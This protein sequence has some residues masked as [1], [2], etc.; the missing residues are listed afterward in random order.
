MKHI[1]FVIAI[2]L[3]FITG[4]LSG[5]QYHINVNSINAPGATSKLKY[6]LFPGLKN[7]SDTDL[8]YREYAKYV[9][10][11]MIIKGYQK[12]QSLSEADIA[13]Y[14]SYGIGEPETKQSTVSIPIVGQTGIS[15]VKTTGSLSTFGNTATYSEN[16]TYTPTY[17][18]T[19]V[20]TRTKSYTTY[21]RYIR[22]I[23]I[24]LNEYRKTNKEVQVWNTTVTSTGTSG[25]LRRVFPVMLAASKSYIGGDTGK[26]IIVIMY[27]N[28]TRIAEITGKKQNNVNYQGGANH[29][30][31]FFKKKKKDD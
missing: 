14:L 6:I 12:T 23:A 16:K 4:C 29:I 18:V 2:S 19:G 25:D 7:V 9:N 26:Q 11:T 15:S 21:D 20:R 31:Q 8:Q 1:R 10:H 28:D 3:M 13:V 30:T 17:G 22:L 5:P 27:E 24:D